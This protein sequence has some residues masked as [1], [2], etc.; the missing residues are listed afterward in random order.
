MKKIFAFWKSAFVQYAVRTTDARVINSINIDNIHNLNRFSVIVMFIELF[1]LTVF[2]ITNWHSPGFVRAFGNVCFC[3]I[4]CAIAV[5][6]SRRIIVKYEQKGTISDVTSNLTVALFY[7]LLSAWGTF[8]DVAHY[9]NGEQM[10]TFYIVQFCFICFVVMIPQTS[11]LLISL[12]FAFLHINLYFIDGAAGMQLQNHMIFGI[13][14][15]C[16]NALRYVSL[17]RTAKDAIAIRALNQKL[18]QEATTDEGTGLL[19]RNSFNK[20]RIKLEQSGASQLYL[21]FIDVNGLH[22]F[23]NTKGHDMGDL[24][25]KQIA[26]ACVKQFEA[27]SVYRMGGDEFLIVGQDLDCATIEEKI[28]F[29]KRAIESFGYSISY[30]VSVSAPPYNLSEMLKDADTK[31]LVN[32]RLY[33]ANAGTRAR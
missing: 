4:I 11:C 30:G 32:K 18:Q 1:F 20:N 26:E 29:I 12:S 16:G 17:Q 19:N 21:I 22:E 14:A 7:L 24:M 9:A 5:I 28:Q 6:I 25:L 2:T 10:L 15:I 33:Y 3:I 31:M 27:E 13:I 8:V 23:N